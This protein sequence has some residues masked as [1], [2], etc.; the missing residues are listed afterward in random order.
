[1]VHTFWKFITIFL[2]TYR[3]TC[4]SIGSVR[5]HTP[6]FLAHR[7]HHMEVTKLQLNLLTK[8]LGKLFE[9]EPLTKLSSQT[10]VAWQ[11]DSL[12]PNCPICAAKFTLNFRKHHCRLCGRIICNNCFSEL[13]W[14]SV[15]KTDKI[16]GV[17]ACTECRTTLQLQTK[18]EEEE[19]HPLATY[20]K[21]GP[22]FFN[23]FYVF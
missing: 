10:V 12:I 20:Q 18:D 22:L 17:R 21:V 3:L 2:G 5:R 9:I 15:L 23:D 7:R 8:R 11:K 19:E 14:T 4:R 16:G 1:M 6:Q 13:T